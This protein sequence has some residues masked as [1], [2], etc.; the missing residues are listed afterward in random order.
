[1]IVLRIHGWYPER[2][3]IDGHSLE[4]QKLGEAIARQNRLA[5]A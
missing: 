1:M 2:G 5:Q 4:C 3:W